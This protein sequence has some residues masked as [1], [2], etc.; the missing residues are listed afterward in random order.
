[1]QPEDA[2]AHLRAIP[3]LGPVYANLVELRATGVS[4]VMTLNEP[5]LRSY[6]KRYYHLSDLPEENEVRRMAELWRPFRTW[7]GV[8]IR[9]SGDRDGVPWEDRR[10]VR[11]RVPGS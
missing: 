9:V 11:P 2:V 1:M 8:L 4:D 7:A 10:P 3:G 5:R 6:L